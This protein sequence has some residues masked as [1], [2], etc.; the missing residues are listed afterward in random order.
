MTWSKSQLILPKSKEEN[1]EAR[2]KDSHSN[3]LS[4]QPP[5]SFHEKQN[6]KSTWRHSSY[7]KSG[8][9]DYDQLPF[10]IKTMGE[11]LL[12]TCELKDS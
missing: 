11:L 9:K 5:A 10:K 1:V 7:M 12:M 4:S 6:K 3:S 8:Y 2:M